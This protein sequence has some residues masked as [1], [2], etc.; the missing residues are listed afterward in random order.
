MATTNADIVRDIL[1]EAYMEI[2]GRGLVSS[3]E[4]DTLREELDEFTNHGIEER[5]LTED[6][7]YEIENKEYLGYSWKEK[8]NE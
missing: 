3:L 5:S 2:V 7:I 1:N 6:E 4:M 8:E